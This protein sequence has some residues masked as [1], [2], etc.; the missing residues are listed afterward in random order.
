[1]TSPI[2]RFGSE[3]RSEHTQKGPAMQQGFGPHGVISTAEIVITITVAVLALI[4]FVYMGYRTRRQ[5][6]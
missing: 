2:T 3:H 5:H 6:A 4:A 1:M